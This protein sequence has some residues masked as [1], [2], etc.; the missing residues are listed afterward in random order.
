MK[1]AIKCVYT[2][3]G[4][5]WPAS[6]AMILMVL[7]GC[8]SKYVWHNPARDATAYNQ[9]YY[10]CE[11]E[12]AQYSFHMGKAGKASM[13]E[14]HLKE[15]MTAK[16][17]LWVREQDVNAALPATKLDQSVATE[18][19]GHALSFTNKCNKTIWVG[20][21][22][23]A[24]FSPL[25]GGGWEMLPDPK[26]ASPKIINVP[27][28]WAG[29]FWTATGCKFDPKTNKCPRIGVPCCD[30]GSCDVGDQWFGLYCKQSGKPPASLVEFA[31]DAPGGH[32]PYDTY[33]ISYVDGYNVGIEFKPKEGTYNM[34]ADPDPERK[35]PWCGTAGCSKA[36]V[37]PDN[38]KHPD[39]KSC[40][41]PCGKYND[42]KHCCVC[43]KTDA[44]CVCPTEKGHERST[45]CAGSY[46]CSIKNPNSPLNMIC[47]PLGE[48]RPDAAW[49][50]DGK[51]YI[52]NIQKV[53]SY[54]YAWQY[55]DF[56]GTFNCRKTNGMV[57]YTVTFTCPGE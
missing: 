54:V 3:S 32:G 57:D 20:S 30:T 46:G 22:G 14:N 56:A 2:S 42:A 48:K 39:G 50:S 9:D 34:D 45:C 15:C 19:N 27:K 26:G 29:R 35:T 12:A 21:T 1:Q 8:S 18:T 6:I 47:D 38:L 24:G 4:I 7:I 44:S 36:P 17:Y 25:G 41:S 16:G 43:S 31:F 55:D 11:N 23:N 53:C 37:C 33:D 51:A 49:E 52:N 28:G 5:L 40:I 10:A 13:V